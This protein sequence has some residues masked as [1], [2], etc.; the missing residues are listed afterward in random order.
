MTASVLVTVMAS[1]FREDRR[2]VE[3]A[4][5]RY[6]LGDLAD[7]TGLPREQLFVSMDGVPIPRTPVCLSRWRAALSWVLCCGPQAPIDSWDLTRP[8]PGSAVHV[9]V[10]PGAEAIG[11]GAAIAAWL[12]VSGTTAIVIAMAINL[13]L[14]AAI[15]IG[16][17]ALAQSLMRPSTHDTESTAPGARR[18]VSGGRN[19]LPRYA[20]LPQVLGKHR[21]FPP[22]CAAI[23]TAVEGNALWQYAIYTFGY[24]PLELSELK[25]GE[26]PLFKANTSLV[27]SGRM[28]ADADNFVRDGKVLAVLELRR[29]AA[30]D[31]AM[32]LFASDVQEEYVGI[33]LT[34]GKGWVRRR[35]KDRTTRIVI[36]VSFNE[37]LIRLGDSGG[38]NNRKV[39]IEARYRVA[40]LAGAIWDS[41]SDI[42][43]EDATRSSLHFTR[44]ADVDAAQYEVEV[45]RFT[46][47]GAD[48][49][50]I[51]DVMWSSMLSHRSGPVVLETRL[52]RVALKVKLTGQFPARVEDFNGVAQTICPDWDSA[53]G[54]WIER[55]TTNPAGLYRHVLQGKANARPVA[56]SRIDLTALQAWHTECISKGF[57]FNYVT[58][59]RV[60]VLKM[61]ENIAAVGR[62]STGVLDGKH[63][64]IREHDLTGA[65][66]QH[67]T[68]R[69][70]RSYQARRRYTEIPH[71]IKMQFVDP[72]SG[73]LDTERIVPDD[74]YTTTTATK[75]ER[76]EMPGITSADQAYKLG[77]YFLAVLRLRPEEYVIQTDFE[78]A[79]LNRGD[80]VKFA[81][82][83]ALLGLHTGRVIS[84]T[85]DGG[86]ACT[87][88]VVDTACVMEAGKTY[89]I[90]FRRSTDGA[91]ITAGIVLDIGS[92][93]TLVF[94][95]PIASGSPQPAA[96]VLFMFGEL[97][98]EAIDCIVKDIDYDADLGATITLIDANSGI[99]TADTQ[100]IPRYDPQI[101]IPP[102]QQPGALPKVRVASVT[103]TGTTKGETR[104]GGTKPGIRIKLQPGRGTVSP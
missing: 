3:I 19:E 6:T 39:R 64:V 25:I 94:T 68:P 76:L 1:P 13:I 60:T 27:Y 53:S 7:A 14:N 74:G 28:N 81:H 82:D 21:F 37:G 8:A 23:Y 58:Q 32:T 89:G 2:F 99:L 104:G 63:T 10:R 31:T 102:K 71:A 42:V 55:V 30:S 5:G 66:V 77:R 35:T 84:A 73:W 50:I 54:T 18:T 43:A 88:V 83:A 41:F 97:G 87:G 70:I 91:T 72:A 15:A 33:R 49:G 20:P 47:E 9:L 44:E 79:N 36:I 17:G 46:P 103:G 85:I 52:C 16:L 22:Y 56:D 34:K 45:R 40:G 65:P 93:T 57:E 59:G 12:G 69:N 90:R 38:A 96:G 4:A 95:A 78:H 11:I 92:Q 24:G 80:W 26:E 29:G 98:E 101:T 100:A 61:I 51:D 67:F 75:F 86:G 62:A 48:P